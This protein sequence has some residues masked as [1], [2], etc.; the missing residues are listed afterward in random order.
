MISV[1][2]SVRILRVEELH[3]RASMDPCY[4]DLEATAVYRPGREI[5]DSRHGETVPADFDKH[6]E[7]STRAS[8]EFEY[9]FG[10]EPKNGDVLSFKHVQVVRAP[11]H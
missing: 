10:R 5:H 8:L 7:R 11:L 9:V 6:I 1:D 2:D 3:L 4:S